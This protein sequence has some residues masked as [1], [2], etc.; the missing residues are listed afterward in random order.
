MAQ[1]TPTYVCEDV[2]QKNGKDS[3]LVCT[4]RI[5]TQASR[6]L[7]EP[8]RMILKGTYGKDRPRL[9]KLLD[10]LGLLSIVGVFLLTAWILWPQK[11]PDF[12]RVDA[13]VAPTEIVTGADSTLTFRYENTS[14]TELKNARVQLGY[15]AHFVVGD[16]T[17]DTGEPLTPDVISLGTI[18]PGG[19]GYLHIRGTMFGDVGG[20]QTFATSFTYQYGQNDQE[21]TKTI[22]HTFSPARSSLALE[23]HLPDHLVRSQT[24]N[25]SIVYTNKGTLT[26]PNLMIVPAWPDGFKLKTTSLSTKNGTWDVKGIAPGETGEITFTGT[27]GKSEDAAFSF[28]PSFSFS[29]A[30]YKQETLASTIG[31]L[32]SP[33]ALSINPDAD[34][35]TPG[36]KLPTKVTLENQSD[37]SVHDVTI[38]LSGDANVF[39]TQTAKTEL[40]EAIPPRTTQTVDLMLPVRTSLSK[41]SATTHPTGKVQA[42]VDFSFDA[43]EDTI[44]SNTESDA[45][46]LPM[47]TPVALSVFSRYYTEGG[48]QLGRGSLPPIVGEATTYWIFW[49]LTGTVNEITRVHIEA[50]LP[51]NVTLTG[52]S[53]VSTGTALTLDDGSA[54]WDI[55]SLP[56]TLS[57]GKIVGA[58]F[59]VKLT[60]TADQIGTT[61]MLIN[62]TRLTATDGFTKSLV[63]GSAKAVTT[64]TWNDAIALPFA[65]V[66]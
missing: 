59:E 48:D 2:P 16:V 15:P 37:Y 54:V 26:F 4:L 29:D 63:A 17:S 1:E 52:R 22:E 66:E 60:P 49:N 25:G 24:I 23:L 47:T 21:D 28:A 12:I 3:V 19:Y 13:S 51:S 40:K 45:V 9:H 30:S 61:P 8:A 34:V 46:T 36:A 5:G 50:A 64:Q 33:L 43:G 53:S 20:K 42:Y 65:T 38:T 27:F 56:A 44:V 39:S 10:I 55:D 41:S 62:T 58:A 7:H 6:H 31:L 35:L 18:P 32:P 57:T 11:T 14:K